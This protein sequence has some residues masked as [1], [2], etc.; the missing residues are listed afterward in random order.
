MPHCIVRKEYGPSSNS[1][2]H[3]RDFKVRRN[4]VHGMLAVLRRTFAREYGEVHI[5]ED[6]LNALPED[7]NI[8]DLIPQ[9]EEHQLEAHVSQ[10]STRVSQQ[11][12][13]AQ[14]STQ[15]TNQSSNESSDEPAALVQEEVVYF[16]ITSQLLARTTLSGRISTINLQLSS[17]WRKMYGLMQTMRKLS[18]M[19]NS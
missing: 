3:F 19:M 10:L 17:I 16:G 18:I 15:Q 6:N 2:R 4:V 14:Q 5:N 12:Q 11:D 8:F 7:G 13:P 9:V 1:I